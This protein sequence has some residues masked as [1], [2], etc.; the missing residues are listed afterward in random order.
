VLTALYLAFIEHGVAGSGDIF[1]SLVIRYLK[2][3][4]TNIT[5]WIYVPVVNKTPKISVDFEN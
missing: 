3:L 4:L 5:S 1:Y 2:S